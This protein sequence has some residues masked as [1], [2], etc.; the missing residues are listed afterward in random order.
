LLE[1]HAGGLDSRQA[2]AV[3]ALPLAE[4]NDAHLAPP[5]IENNE[6]GRA[7][8][9]RDHD[10]RYQERRGPNRDYGRGRGL[11]RGGGRVVP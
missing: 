11:N 1:Q 10:P 8:C 9:R 3:E 4:E 5:V 2:V 7:L 6:H